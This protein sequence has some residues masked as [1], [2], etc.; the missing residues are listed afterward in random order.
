MRCPVERP[1]HRRLDAHDAVRS[2]KIELGILQRPERRLVLQRRRQRLALLGPTH[3][4]AHARFLN[5]DLPDARLL[6]DANELADPFGAGLIDPA[7][8]ERLITR[9]ASPDRA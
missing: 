7:G 1:D 8:A 9:R 3:R 5:R 2:D 4:Y 6:D